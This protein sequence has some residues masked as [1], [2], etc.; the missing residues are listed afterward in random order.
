M[1]SVELSSSVNSPG[2]LLNLQRQLTET[3][4]QLRGAQS[5]DDGEHL[6]LDVTRI[7]RTL[8]N[9]LRVTDGPVDNHT[10]LGQTSLPQTL[11]TLYTLAL[12]GSATPDLIYSAPI[13]EILRVSAN[14]CM[15][16]DDNRG[17]L[18]DAGLP[19]ALVSLLEGYAESIPPP[20]YSRPLPL[21]SAHLKLIRAAI[22]VLLNASVGFDPVKYR[23]IS[24]EAGKTI[25]KLST[26]IYPTGSWLV[27]PTLDNISES[28]LE[29]A[30]TLRSSL[31]NWAW[32]T[33]IELKDVKDESLQIFTPDVLPFLTPPL[34]AF[35]SPHVA[36]L[37]NGLPT[38]LSATLLQ[39]DFESLEESCSLIESLSLDVED[40]RLSLAR[41]HQFPAE[42]GGVPCFSC[43]LD[44]L[45]QG[46]T[47]PLW[48]DMPS[49]F[50]AKRK[51]K[52]FEMFKAALIKTV[53]EVVGEERNE[54][55][56]WD[57]SEVG[58]SGGQFVS[59]MVQWLKKCVHDMEKGDGEYSSRNDLVICASLSLGNLARREKNASVLLSPP[60]S[61]APVLTSV[62]LL[63]PS[64]DIK[65]K[66]GVLGLLKHLAQSSF[67]SSSIQSY[68]S[69][70]ETVKCVCE[71]GIWDQRA[72][73]MA[74]VVQISAIG[75]V[76]HLCNA[77]VENTF[78][79]VLPSRT[80]SPT[81]QTGLSQILALVKRSDSVPVKSEGT[82]VLVNVVKSLWSSDIIG[83]TPSAL[84]T[85]SEG[86]GHSESEDIK[87]KRQEAKQTILTLPCAS[88]LANLVA[89][90]AKYPLLVNEGIVA[91]TLLSTQKT[92]APLVLQAILSPVLLEPPPSAEPPSASSSVAT[93]LS[94]PTI[95]TPSTRGRLPVPRTALDMLIAVLKNVDNPV[96]FQP[97]VRINV[98]S[99]LIQVGRN[100]AEEEEYAKVKETVKPVMEELLESLRGATGIE[101]ALAKAV[102]RV[103]ETWV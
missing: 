89:R 67:Q 3:A 81:L 62:H 70:A 95:A 85:N 42:H 34:L 37:P 53:V 15:D 40:V 69:K 44:F 6:W 18:L 24:L 14:L 59:R 64:S 84:P 23:L 31:S 73:A 25:L 9:A 103:I 52:G 13:L 96:N 72:D 36:A 63:S 29:E 91:L 99:L 33:I 77:N 88:A 80:E 4:N 92:G 97:E 93:E 68:L 47:P 22:G 54:D 98:C 79:L 94:S 28:D 74:E 1:P 100:S 16:H 7:C 101:G 38:E 87:R 8:A 82:R 83:A 60:H 27:Q 48:K 19:Q 11:N 17:L 61:L 10:A 39:A 78:A 76:K 41:G 21:D 56:L 12:Q 20:P 43:I 32:R 90:S 35:T 49:S 26:A 86:E 57:D 58:T 5:A 102:N 46:E 71:C 55:V 2:D 51:E 50:D 65:M 75:V 30:W 45:E 66:H